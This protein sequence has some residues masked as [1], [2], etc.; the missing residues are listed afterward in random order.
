MGDWLK[1]PRGG[2]G[3]TSSGAP[4]SPSAW[5]GRDSPSVAHSQMGEASTARRIDLF[6]CKLRV[7][8]DRAWASLHT[9]S[10]FESSPVYEVGA[11]PPAS[12][13][14][15]TI[16]SDILPS[17]MGVLNA[18]ASPGNAWQSATPDHLTNVGYTNR[19]RSP[20]DPAAFTPRRDNSRSPR[21]P[22]S[23]PSLPCRSGLHPTAK[24]ADTF[25]T[26]TNTAPSHPPVEMI[27]E[28]ATPVRTG[29]TTDMNWA[30]M[31]EEEENSQCELEDSASMSVLNS[32]KR[33]DPDYMEQRR[34]VRNAKKEVTE[35]F[36]K[37]VES[38]GDTEGEDVAADYHFNTEEQLK[39]RAQKRRLEDCG[40][41]FCT[42]DISPS[43]DTFT[44]W[45]YQEVENKTAVQIS[46]VKV[47]APHHY[48][49]V[50]HNTEDR[51]EVLAGGP[52]YMRKRMIYTTPWEPG[53]DTHKVLAKKMAVWL[54]LLNVDPMMEG[55][56]KSLL[57]SL[58]EV[59][60]VAGITEK[61][62]AKFAN[63]RGCVL[64]DMTKTLPSVLVLH[65]NG[66]K[67][68]V[69]IWDRVSEL[70]LQQEELGEFRIK[71]QSRATEEDIEKF[72]SLESKVRETELLEA[73][74]LRRRSRVRWVKEGDTNSKYFFQR[75][76][77]KQ[78]HEKITSLM[79]EAGHKIEDEDRI[80]K[81][82]HSYYQ[83]LYMS[84]LEGAQDREERAEV[85][86]LVDRGLTEEDNQML[87]ELPCVQ[88]ITGMV[89]SLPKEK[90]PG[91][92]DLTADVLQESWE[93]MGDRCVWFI[94]EIWV[95][96]NLPE[97]NKTAVV[98]LLP[99]NNERTLLR[100]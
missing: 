38:A 67:K 66:V 37:I 13:I 73:S 21:S 63:I 49:V 56:G 12:N 22:R 6:N 14:R 80:L 95:N 31:V 100:N 87:A 24:D 71:V 79:D 23:P 92:D 77:S 17:Q 83:N 35:A 29:P 3:S 46:H 61:M 55:L 85:L 43:R 18:Q 8:M 7:T 58:G 40:V 93:W 60:Q 41:V 59:L 57:S 89:D 82:V 39:I 1:K 78:A 68:R 52:Y 76:K 34:W 48:P 94:Q 9:N 36:S 5:R 74:I 28:A 51:D 98:K 11:S 33:A 47:L 86:N 20:R 81:T 84:Q 44:Q 99:K 19:T 16:N 70:R 72:R 96:H 4:K 26:Q 91:D 88:E 97:I 65:M 45:L 53:F 42:V 27:P 64:M 90:A 62:E 15:D 2:G 25:A 54:D 32:A 69:K 10:A 75:L 30:A 50:L